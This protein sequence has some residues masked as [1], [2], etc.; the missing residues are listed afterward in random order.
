MAV[1]AGFQV[2][3]TNDRGLQRVTEIRVLI[4]DDLEL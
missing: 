4:L 2:F 1:N 3:L